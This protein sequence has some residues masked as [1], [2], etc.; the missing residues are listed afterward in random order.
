PSSSCTTLRGPRLFLLS[1]HGSQVVSPRLTRPH[2]RRYCSVYYRIRQRV[3][4]GT[5]EIGRLD[6]RLA[7]RGQHLSPA[8]RR[9]ATFFAAHRE[10]VAFL[11]AA[12]IAGKLETSDATVVR[13]AQSLGYTGLPELKRELV[14]A[15]RVRATPASR[16]GA[17]LEDLGSTLEEALDHVLTLQID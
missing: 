7:A 10:E 3:V 13:T 4:T 1:P 11:S 2:Q 5:T 6:E 8:E 12:E 14:A 17:A 15:L 9:A 16:L